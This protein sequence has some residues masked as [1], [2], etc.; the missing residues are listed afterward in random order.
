MSTVSFL[1]FISESLAQ[2]YVIPVYI[3]E[4][5]ASL[6]PSSIVFIQG[7]NRNEQLCQNT[8]YVISNITFYELKSTKPESNFSVSV[9]FGAITLFFLSSFVSFLFLSKKI[10]PKPDKDNKN[11]EKMI[12]LD[13]SK[14]KATENLKKNYT[15][16]IYLLMI[17]FSISFFMYG[18]LLGLQSYSTLA[19]SHLAFN[20]S[21]NFGNLML[22]L[23]IFFSIVSFKLSVRAI[24]IEFLVALSI[25]IYIVYISF[26]SPCPPLNKHWSGS[27]L[28][29]IAWIVCECLFLRLRCVIAANLEKYGQKILII[30]GWITLLGQVCGG[31]IIYILV[32]IL[33]VFVARADCQ[34]DSKLC[35]K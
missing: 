11:D 14:D 8:S 1:P 7:I 23:V 22:P 15:E 4:G 28:I 31:I 16:I 2:E 32:D 33:K 3:G 13:N 30:L 29:V 21:I 19:Y 27:A 24:T 34:D 12:F 18:V 5:F 6:V 9:F 10:A 35:R 20:L 25:S 26:C 17:S